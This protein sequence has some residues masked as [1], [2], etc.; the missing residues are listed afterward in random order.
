M[1]ATTDYPKEVVELTRGILERRIGFQPVCVACFLAGQTGQLQGDDRP[2]F[3]E[4]S[5]RFVTINGTGEDSTIP[6]HADVTLKCPEC[7]YHQH[8]GVPITDQDFEIYD[9]LLGGP[10]YKFDAVLAFARNDDGSFDDEQL[11]A[12]GYLA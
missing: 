12:L 2:S 11:A 3:P 10:P 7:R 5:V 4:L 9:D 6:V 1:T 8:H